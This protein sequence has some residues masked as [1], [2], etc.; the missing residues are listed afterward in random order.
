MNADDDPLSRST[1]LATIHHQVE[2]I[3]CMV[4]NDRHIGPDVRKPIFRVC[5]QVRFKPACSATVTN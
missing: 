4:M 1:N 5:D 3:H 2:A